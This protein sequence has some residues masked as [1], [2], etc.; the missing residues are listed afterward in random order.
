MAA[1]TNASR[2]IH[3]TSHFTNN[4]PINTISSK[5]N[6]LSI[7]TTPSQSVCGSTTISESFENKYKEQEKQL[8]LQQQQ[9]QQSK[10]NQAYNQ[11]KNSHLKC[12]LASP[13]LL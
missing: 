3:D 6:N 12:P 5:F 9:I 13:S 1:S 4:N 8:I 2:S 11:L 7:S 10:L